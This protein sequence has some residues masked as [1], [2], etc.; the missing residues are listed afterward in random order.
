M[1]WSIIGQVGMAGFYPPEDAYFILFQTEWTFTRYGGGS[2]T[3]EISKASCAFGI[4][5]IKK[6]RESLENLVEKGSKFVREDP[7][8]KSLAFVWYHYDPDLK[9]GSCNFFWGLEDDEW[10]RVQPYLMEAMARQYQ[11]RFNASGGFSVEDNPNTERS[12]T[13]NEFEAGFAKRLYDPQMRMLI[14]KVCGF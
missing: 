13:V 14:P 7:A 6:A 1:S 5:R 3:D 10:E 4:Y 8:E 2:L 11:V 12:P 9:S